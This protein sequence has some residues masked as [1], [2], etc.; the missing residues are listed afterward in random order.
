[1][2][3]NLAEIRNDFTECHA[4]MQESLVLLEST[5]RAIDQFNKALD[6]LSQ[7]IQALELSDVG[8]RTWEQ[9]RKDLETQFNHRLIALFTAIGA[10]AAAIA[11]WHSWG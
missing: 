9:Q 10:I 7:K 1:M 8:R 11:V 3:G 6:T 5:S 4:A 2:E